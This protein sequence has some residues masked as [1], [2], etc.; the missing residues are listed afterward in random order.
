MAPALILSPLDLSFPIDL[1]HTAKDEEKR[2]V[3]PIGYSQPNPFPTFLVLNLT[4]PPQ[5]RRELL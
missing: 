3:S 2:K 4:N 5:T 1:S